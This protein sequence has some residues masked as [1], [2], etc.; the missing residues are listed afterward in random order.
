[1]DEVNISYLNSI[2]I[3]HHGRRN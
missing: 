1:M 2:L 3:L